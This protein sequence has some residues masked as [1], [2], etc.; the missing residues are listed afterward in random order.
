MT[1]IDI[2][3]PPNIAEDEEVARIIFSPSMIEGDKVAPSAFFMDN[4]RNRQETYISVW[5]CSSRMP[6]IENVTFR[7][8]RDGDTLA[9]YAKINVSECHTIRFEDYHAHVMPHP[10][11]GN[12]AHAGIHVGR[13]TEPIKGQCYDPGYLMFATMI[14]GKCT[15]V[16][17]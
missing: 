14:A 3:V 17:F 5:R 11:K 8:R 6:S 10:S 4:L 13:G 12:P 7:P 2:I 15:L 16:L 9:G 1:L